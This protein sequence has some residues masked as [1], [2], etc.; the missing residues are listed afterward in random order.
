[1]KRYVKR[2]L[3][4][5]LTAL[6]FLT[7][8][9][10][11]ADKDIQ[12][13]VGLNEDQ[14]FKI[15]R[16]TATVP[17]AMIFVTTQKNIYEKA[18]GSEIW[19]ID[20]SNGTF[21]TY[22]RESLQNFLAQMK[23]MVLMAA[24]RGIELTEEEKRLAKEAADAYYGKL[25]E[26]DIAYM[27][28]TPGTAKSVY[29]QYCLANKLVE[30]LTKDVNVEVSDSEA[31][32]IQVEQILI[33]TYAVDANGNQAPLS[34]EDKAAKR[35]TAEEALHKAESGTDFSVLAESYNEGDA[36]NYK[37]GRGEFPESFEEAAFALSDGELSGIVETEYGY[38]IIKCIED[39]DMEGTE[40]HKKEIAERKKSEA[41]SKV[42][43]T[44]T[45]GLTAEYNKAAWDQIRF[46][47][48]AR[49]E[50]A[51]FYEEYKA[52]FGVQ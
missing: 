36:V 4:G 51:D 14:L 18:Y 33:K 37:V 45:A 12:F 44:F 46:T 10:K 49:A 32:I 2:L 48:E 23:C 11:L 34:E 13:T 31:R 6:L 19:D 52:V 17:E 20:L 26:A 1:M 25:S 47:G 50:G 21:E 42:Y 43:D 22:V 7:G 15:G 5:I 8:C 35:Q 40:M 38:H 16:E 3:A 9:S 24:D 29:E 41:F 39:Y 28:L 27:K 30:E